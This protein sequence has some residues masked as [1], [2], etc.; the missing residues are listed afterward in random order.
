ML[1]LALGIA[2]LAAFLVLTRL[3]VAADPARLAQR[4]RL[5]GALGACAAGAILIAAG[6]GGFGFALL[7]LGGALF[8]GFLRR[9]SVEAD[10][11]GGPSGGREDLEHGARARRRNPARQS[12]MTEDEAYQVL[13]LDP[14]AGPDEIRRAH[15]ALMQK[16]HP[17]RGG[18]TWLSSRINQAKDV[19]LR[20]RS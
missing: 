17:D 15:R 4:L 9:G 11:N 18:S 12:A 2:A 3:Y 16:L 1:P 7:I 5:A 19:L 14:G 13:G 10:Q 20:S 8:A 6:R